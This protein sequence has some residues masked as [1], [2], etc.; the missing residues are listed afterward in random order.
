MDTSSAPPT[1]PS[2]Q[3]RKGDPVQ[4]FY[5]MNA[6]A[7]GYFPVPNLAAGCLRPRFGRTD[8]WIDAMVEADWPPTEA[9]GSSKA[10]S[11]PGVPC[12]KIRH[13][14]PN[15][16]NA[17]GERLNPEKDSDMVLWM[18]PADVRALNLMHPAG[19][20]PS[21]SVS[22]SILVVRW[23]GE[24]TK[25]NVEQWGAASSS[26]SDEY[27]SAFL[28]DC[29]YSHLGPDY[30]VFS[31]FVQSGADMLKLQPPA[32]VASMCGRHRC[33]CYFLW[34]VLATDGEGD[35]SGMVEQARWP[36]PVGPEGF[37]R[38]LAGCG[39]I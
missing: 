7:G 36:P 10:S 35:Q 20:R 24:Q 29:V 11:T 8:G 38:G 6:D 21:V 15:W 17:A 2:V 32:I 4:V 27:V 5:R 39:G 16:S 9:S 12:I 37:R 34:P 19:G 13:T 25:F 14:H 1:P 26:V 28:D 31:V 18:N 33:G 22:L 3:Y 30:E 23:G